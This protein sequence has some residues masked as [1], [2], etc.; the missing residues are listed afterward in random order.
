MKNVI[1]L[2]L[3]F[4]ILGCEK[5]NELTSKIELENLY[6]IKDDPTDPVK[7][8]IYEIYSEYGVPVYFNDTMERFLSKK[9]LQEKTCTV[10]KH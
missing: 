4:L 2:I 8:R 1:Y 5:E 6:E 7:H 3:S 9:M 10:M